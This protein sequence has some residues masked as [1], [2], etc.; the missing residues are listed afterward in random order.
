MTE[1]RNEGNIPALFRRY[2]RIRRFTAGRQIFMR[3]DPADEIYY[4]ERGKVRAYL[5]YPDGT[6]RT[7]CFV[8]EG[9]LVGEEVVAEPPE[10][11]VCVEA[12]TDLLM[13]GMDAGTLLKGCT[14]ETE[15]LAELMVL[16]MKKIELLCGW[17]FYA[18][19]TRN[20][21]KLACFLYSNTNGRQTEVRYTQEQIAAVTGMSRVSVSNCLRDFAERGLVRQ[22]YKRIIVLDR[23]GLKRVFGEQNFY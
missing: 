10:R 5:L 17:I 11:I 7:L 4:L 15:S 22:A 8:E 12:E 23:D 21:A 3:G 1:K 9:N 18:Q 6:E 19:F 16:Y 14:G 2:G 13:Y 20:D